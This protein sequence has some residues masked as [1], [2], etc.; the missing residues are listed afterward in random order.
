MKTETRILRFKDKPPTSIKLAP[1]TWEAVELVSERCNMRWTE[2]TRDVLS[3]A[4][5]GDNRTELI[6]TA[7]IET[8]TTLSFP[9]PMD[10]RSEIWSEHPIMSGASELRDKEFNAFV[11]HSSKIMETINLGGFEIIVGFDS[12]HHP[13]VGIRNGLRNG[14]NLAIVQN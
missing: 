12:D 10:Q 8:L 1:L 2:W 9:L 14:I 4:A 5:P 6:R 11:A 13:F 3:R 7:L